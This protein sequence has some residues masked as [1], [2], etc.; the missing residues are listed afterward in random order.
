MDSAGHLGPKIGLHNDLGTRPEKDPYQHMDVD[1]DLDPDQEV[2]LDQDPDQDQDLD[3][4][5]EL[6]L[7]R[8]LPV[9]PFPEWS[10]R[11]APEPDDHLCDSKAMRPTRPAQ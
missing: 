11:P 9:D 8:A 7:D 3:L 10:L 2:G 4:V 1:Q 6:D 5:L